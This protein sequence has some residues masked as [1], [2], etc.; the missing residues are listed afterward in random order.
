MSN[1]RPDPFTTTRLQKI[2]TAYEK[3]CTDHH[4]KISG[5][6]G[7]INKATLRN[8]D[9]SELERKL[10][11][12]IEIGRIR[13]VKLRLL[14]TMLAASKSGNDVEV[15]SE[16]IISFNGTQITLNSEEAY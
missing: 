13:E 7:A 3:G 12:L 10:A 1:N 16:V 14:L 15:R 2:V 4:C 11:G 5:V 8:T 6:R 9:T